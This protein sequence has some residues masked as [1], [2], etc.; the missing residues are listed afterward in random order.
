MRAIFCAVPAFMRVEPAQDFGVGSRNDRRFGGARQWRTAALVSATVYAPKARAR[1]IAATTKAAPPLAEM[2]MT[3]SRRIHAFAHRSVA[4][5]SIVFGAFYGTGH[6]RGVRRQMCAR[7]SSGG[8]PKVGGSSAASSTASVRWYPRRRSA[9]R[10][11][12]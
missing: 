6:C 7:T 4:G 2:P 8:V 3:A 11:L 5:G 12:A 10:R 1:D 9:V